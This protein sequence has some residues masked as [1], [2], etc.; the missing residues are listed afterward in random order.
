MQ[1]QI[2]ETIH[3]I[4]HVLTIPIAVIAALLYAPKYGYNRGKAILYSLTMMVIIVLFT[5]ACKWVPG[6]FGFTVFINAARTFP[7]VPLFSLLLSRVW[8]IP[9]WQGVDFMTPIMFFA[10][11]VVLIGCTM[12]GCGQAVPRDWGV[13]SA[14]AGCKVFPMDLIDMLGTFA[15][16]FLSMAYAKRLHYR[17]NGR[18]FALSMICLGSIRFFLQLESLDRYYGI[19]GFN[20]ETIISIISIVIGAVIYQHNE[21]RVQNI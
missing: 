4:T 9:T 12:L 7:F 3:G 18:V 19:R 20:D 6:W 8:K 17:G 2:L 5:Y 13:Y 14:L 16:A 21:N 15:I 10:R 11:T 1:I